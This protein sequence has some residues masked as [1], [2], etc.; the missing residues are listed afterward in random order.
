MST[1]DRPDRTAPTPEP[2]PAPDTAQESTMNDERETQPLGTTPAAETQPLGTTRSADETQPIGTRHGDPRPWEVDDTAAAAT[3]E[4][5]P[6]PAT[7]TPPPVPVAT[8]VR[9]GTIVWG[10]VL[11]AV[12]VGFLALAAGLT[13]DVELAFIAI[14][15]LAGVGLVAGAVVTAVRRNQHT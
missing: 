6:G 14:V 4:P 11:A 2:T 15:A 9:V 8:D 1:D 3:A 7:A 12:G 10:L 13:F 5:T